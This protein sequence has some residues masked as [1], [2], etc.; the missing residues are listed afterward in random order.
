[1]ISHSDISIYTIIVNNEVCGYVYNQKQGIEFISRIASILQK[2]LYKE[3]PYKTFYQER[4]LELNTIKLYCMKKGVIY[5]SSLKLLYTISLKSINKLDFKAKD[6]LK[7][8]IEPPLIEPPLIEPQL[9]EPQLIEEEL[10]ENN[11]YSI[12]SDGNNYSS[13]DEPLITYPSFL[14]KCKYQM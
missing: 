7:N 10:S 1:M 3:K 13:S 6:F 11:S 12:S 14:A 4:I 8:V 5:N 2:E 9:I